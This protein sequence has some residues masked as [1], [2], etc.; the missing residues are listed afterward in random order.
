[1]GGFFNNCKESGAYLEAPVKRCG[2]LI[3]NIKYCD[4]LS[5]VAHFIGYDDL[6]KLKKMFGLQSYCGVLGHQIMQV[7][8]RNITGMKRHDKK[9]KER[10]RLALDGT[11]S[12]V[13]MRKR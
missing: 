12:A 8:K 6:P 4:S 3:D 11:E 9:W 7:P 1:M 10:Q 5:E 2:Y 13:E